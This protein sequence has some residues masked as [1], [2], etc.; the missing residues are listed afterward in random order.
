MSKIE[1]YEELKK[2]HQK[3]VRLT[4]RINGNLADA[5]VHKRELDERMTVIEE[6][7]AE[8]QKQLARQQTFGNN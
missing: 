6:K 2:E 5:I 7:I 8:R 4:V 1:S 3:C